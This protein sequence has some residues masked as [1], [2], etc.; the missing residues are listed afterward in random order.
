LPVG[1]SQLH[2]YVAKGLVMWWRIVTTELSPLLSLSLT[3]FIH[4]RSLLSLL[5]T[6][7]HFFSPPWVGSWEVSKV[8]CGSGHW[9]TGLTI[10]TAV[11]LCT[12]VSLCHFFHCCSLFLQIQFFHYLSLSFTF[13]TFY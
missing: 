10:L 12:F 6:S 9:Q 7:I 13:L 3:V 1:L 11:K 5:V 2:Y 8:G 4:I